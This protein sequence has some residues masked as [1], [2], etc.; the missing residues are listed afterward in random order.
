MVRSRRISILT[1]PFAILAG[2]YTTT[3]ICPPAPAAQPKPRRSQL[4]GGAQLGAE[5]GHA[6]GKFTHPV[7]TPQQH[8]ADRG[9]V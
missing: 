2:C 1:S 6:L 5:Q 7:R 9:L 4:A 8:P 3:I